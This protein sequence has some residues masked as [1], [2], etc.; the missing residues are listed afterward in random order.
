MNLY[1]KAFRIAN[2]NGKEYLQTWLKNKH[3]SK[4][5]NTNDNWFYILVDGYFYAISQKNDCR[6]TTFGTPDHFN[7]VVKKGIINII[8]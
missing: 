6:S 5:V 7:N 4:I 1:N 3:I 8:N 2:Q